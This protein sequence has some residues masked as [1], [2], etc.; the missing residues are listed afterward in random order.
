MFNDPLKL[1]KTAMHNSWAV[2]HLEDGMIFEGLV[3]SEAVYGIYL[4]IGG[5]EDRLSLFPWRAVS[6]VVYKV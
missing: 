6:R 1:E 3:A 5:S 2:V 4:H